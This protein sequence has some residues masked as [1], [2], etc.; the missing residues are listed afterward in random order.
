MSGAL[1][2]VQRQRD[3]NT[4]G[5]M[6]VRIRGEK[7]LAPLL[8]MIAAHSPI[9]C[10]DIDSYYGDLIATHTDWSVSVHSAMVSPAGALL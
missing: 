5:D 2:W 9:T 10:V 7:P 1:A 6:D 8:S 4:G 3:P